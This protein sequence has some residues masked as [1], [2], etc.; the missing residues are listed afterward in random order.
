M[1]SV[2]LA[3]RLAG[4]AP[5]LLVALAVAAPDDRDVD[6]IAERSVQ[7][8]R[9]LRGI[10]E[11]RHVVVTVGIERAADRR[12]LS[13]HHAARCDDVRPGSRL[14]DGGLGIDA[15]R[16]V[17]VDHAVLVDDAAVPVVGVLVD[18]EVGHHHDV[19]AEIGTQIT[20]RDLH[21]TV[22]VVRAASDGVLRS[23]ERR[24]G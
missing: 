5:V 15:E 10:G 23:R 1:S 21:D 2:D 17:V 16:R 12:H 3:A 19:V 18:T 7:R 6:G 4:V 11:D 20:Q 22:G 24:R 8:T 14:G 9:V 13:V